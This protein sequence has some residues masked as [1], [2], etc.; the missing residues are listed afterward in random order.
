MDFGLYAPRGG[1]KMVLA[2]AHN[3]FLNDLKSGALKTT[4]IIYIQLPLTL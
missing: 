4:C 1:L 2:L 3:W